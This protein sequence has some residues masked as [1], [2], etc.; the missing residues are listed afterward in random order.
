[1]AWIES[2]TCLA[3]HR[4]VIALSRDLRLK[5][6]W[7]T[8]HLHVLWHTILEQQED[9]DLSSWSD[10]QIAAAGGFQGDAAKVVELLLKH[11]WID[12]N[13]TVHDWLDYAGMYLR[14]KYS[15]RKER[16]VEI[17]AKHGRQYPHQVSRQPTNRLLTAD[18]PPT[19]CLPLPDL[20]NQP[21]QTNQPEGAFKNQKPL[22]HKPIEI[23]EDLAQRFWFCQVGGKEDEFK[24]GETVREMVRVGWQTDAIRKEIDR[25]ERDK[26]ERF[27]HLKS[28]LERQK[29]QTEKPQPVTS[30]GMSSEERK[31]RLL[32]RSP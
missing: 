17:W 6:E 24:L 30:R 28:R 7:L 1:M 19:N 21:N 5:P 15:K 31:A 29:S 9:G 11:R 20:P 12:A 10:D 2:H 16:L 25:P 27:F 32:G 23:P 14:G 8:G 18:E 3:R 22:E 13:R 4:K 26:S